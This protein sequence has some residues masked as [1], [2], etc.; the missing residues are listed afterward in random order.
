MKPKGLLISVDGVLT[1]GTSI[2]DMSGEVVAKSVFTAD[3]EYI[4]ALQNILE[5]ALVGNTRVDANMAKD[6]QIRSIGYDK[7]QVAEWADENTISSD[8]LIHIGYSILDLPILLSVGHRYC[9]QDADF[10]IKPHCRLL[11]VPS[12]R[13]VVGCAYLDIRSRWGKELDIQLGVP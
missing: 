6:L 9:P 8:E 5:V 10:F 13:G 1:D 3:L 2:R 11:T 4:R 12:G 7:D